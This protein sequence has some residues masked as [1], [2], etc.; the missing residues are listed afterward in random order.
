M[1]MS[2]EERDI[3]LIL[4]A[5]AIAIPRSAAGSVSLKPPVT[6]TTISWFEIGMFVLRLITAQI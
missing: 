1:A 6:L 4:E 5:I 2:C 3:S